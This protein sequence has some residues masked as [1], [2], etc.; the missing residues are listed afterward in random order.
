MSGKPKMLSVTVSVSL[1]L[2][3]S[4][5]RSNE[6]KNAKSG[7]VCN[8]GGGAGLAEESP[9]LGG[10]AGG[11]GGGGWTSKAPMSMVPPTSRAK[12]GPR[13]SNCPVND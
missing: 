8:V 12:P 13:W 3:V 10:G 6:S 5:A 1:P 2:T 9:L 4:T 11:D 7:G